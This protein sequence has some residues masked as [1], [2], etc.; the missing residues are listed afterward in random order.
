MQS[1]GFYFCLLF[2][3]AKE[4][5]QSVIIRH[6]NRRDHIS[7]ALAV[8]VE[9]T[10]IYPRIDPAL[11]ITGNTVPD[12]KGAPA[13]KARYVGGYIVKKRLFRFMRTDLL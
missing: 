1:E 11:Y 7:A 6:G 9:I 2:T 10:G 3:Y 13:L 12:D 8:P 4:T 5:A